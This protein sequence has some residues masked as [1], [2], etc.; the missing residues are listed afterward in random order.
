MEIEG[1]GQQYLGD[2]L[3]GMIRWE[4]RVERKNGAHFS[5]LGAWWYSPLRWEIKEEKSQKYELSFG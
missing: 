1:R 2:R 5:V 4:V 3:S